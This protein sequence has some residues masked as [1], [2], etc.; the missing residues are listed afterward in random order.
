LAFLSV[1]LHTVPFIYALS[2]SSI[3]RS[4]YMS[5]PAQPFT[6][7]VSYY[8]LMANYISQLLICFESPLSICL[9][10]WAKYMQH[11]NVHIISEDVFITIYLKH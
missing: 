8:I 6:F 5:Q 4:F 10:C 1:L 7:N 11:S 3:R 9:L 2:H